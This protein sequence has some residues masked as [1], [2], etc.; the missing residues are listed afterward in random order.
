MKLAVKTVVNRRD[1]YTKEPGVTMSIFDE[2]FQ[3]RTGR[4]IDGFVN[5]QIGDAV[6]GIEDPIIRN[7]VQNFI[8]SVLPGV[9]GG[10]PDLRDN[11]FANLIR[12]KQ[13]AS[14]VEQV[15]EIERASVQSDTDALVD[16][17][18]WRAR[19]RPKNGGISRFYSRAFANL[20]D[21]AEGDAETFDHLMRPIQES[22]GMIWMDTPS[23]YIQASAHYNKSDMQGQNYPINTYRNSAPPT[24]PVTGNF[25]ANDIYEARYL[26][27]VMMFLR[28]A[29]KSYY[30]DS[31]VA[32]GV[33]GTPPPV[34]LF[35]YLGDYGFNRVP[36]VVET[37]QMEFPPDV[38]YVPVVV[39]NGG[40]N[41]RRVTYVPTRTQISV[42]LTP[43]FTPQKLRKRF[44]LNAIANG[45]MYKDGFI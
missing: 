15:R 25:Y 26:L 39:N 8:D 17:Y 21:Q 19:L 43:T 23:V 13:T 10:T 1:K 12:D 37:Y 30:G 32:K 42:T 4:T 27:A 45:R 28:I 2:F 31:A 35:E 40:D 9:G 29:S 22:N 6:R 44:D 3:T 34:L 38:D 16:S 36:V 14:V 18:D 11:A 33:Y 41:E 7:G 5:N 24:I 20:T